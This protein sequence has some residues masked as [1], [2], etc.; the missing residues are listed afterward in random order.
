MMKSLLLYFVIAFAIMFLSGCASVT[1]GS[2]QNVNVSVTCNGRA[3]PNKCI[4]SNSKGRWT[5][6]T[7]ETKRIWRDKSPLSVMCESATLGGYGGTSDYN[8]NPTVYGNILIGGLIG[9]AIDNSNN[10][11]WSYPEMIEVPSPICGG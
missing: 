1:S 6:H 9:L 2:T 4:V 8:V 5:F 7:P 3:I 10:S 11:L